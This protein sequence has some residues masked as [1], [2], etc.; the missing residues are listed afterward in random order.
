MS[1]LLDTLH[2]RHRELA[3]SLERERARLQDEKTS[4]DEMAQLFSELA[5]RLNREL[6][7]PEP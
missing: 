4:R 7:L 1:E 5:L 3:D 2:Q 6:D